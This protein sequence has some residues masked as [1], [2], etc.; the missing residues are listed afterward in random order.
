MRRKPRR[1]KLVSNWPGLT[2]SWGSEPLPIPATNEKRCGLAATDRG[3]DPETTDL[4]AAIDPASGTVPDAAARLG[5]VPVTIDRIPTIGPTTTGLM[6]GAAIGP[7]IGR[8]AR[9]TIGPETYSRADLMV[10]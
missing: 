10:R 3:G 1:R 8:T 2:S 4:P 5:G 9:P 7:M 6:T